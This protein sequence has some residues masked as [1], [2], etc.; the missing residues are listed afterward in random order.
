MKS[1]LEVI[2]LLAVLL[3][4]AFV[5]IMIPELASSLGNRAPGYVAKNIA[6]TMDGVAAAPE[7]TQIEYD[8]PIDDWKASIN[9]AASPEKTIALVHFTGKDLVWVGRDDTCD[10]LE[11]VFSAGAK[12]VLKKTGGWFGR[13]VPIVGGAANAAWGAAK[14]LGV[15][16]LLD[17]DDVG[18]RVAQRK[19]SKYITSPDLDYKY[20]STKQSDCKGGFEELYDETGFAIAYQFVGPF[21][22]I[23]EAVVEM[24]Q[25]L[26]DDYI[27][28]DPDTLYFS[29]TERLGN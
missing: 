14:P 29:K 7:E 5:I 12:S 17:G 15:D 8:I 24:E 9:P 2:I 21:G 11:N 23:C 3:A 27:Y 26:K 18:A 10:Y 4:S 20:S 25:H 19:V 22:S 28:N 1:L 13:N 6:L 16:H